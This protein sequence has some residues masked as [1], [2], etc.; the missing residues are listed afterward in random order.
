MK[1]T[2]STSAEMTLYRLIFKS[3]YKVESSSTLC[4]ILSSFRW[5]NLFGNR[6]TDLATFR[7]NVSLHG[8]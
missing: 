6:I 5:D 3:E 2:T 1:Q 7:D 8:S 4:R